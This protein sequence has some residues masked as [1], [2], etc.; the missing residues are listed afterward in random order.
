MS[1]YS[2]WQPLVDENGQTALVF[3][4]MRHA[5]VASALR[6]WLADVL[7]RNVSVQPIDAEHFWP[8]F[9]SIVDGYSW[10]EPDIVFGADDGGPVVVIVEAKPGPGGHTAEQLVREVIDTVHATD[11]QRVAMIP[12]GLQI[13]A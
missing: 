1:L 3:G 2:S 13:T 5:P 11:S 6:P 7:G 10:T 4:F 12:A 8:R 9:R